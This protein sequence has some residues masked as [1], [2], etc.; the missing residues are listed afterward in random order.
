MVTTNDSRKYVL[1]AKIPGSDPFWLEGMV[2]SAAEGRGYAKIHRSNPARGVLLL[3]QLGSQLYQLRLP[4]MQQLEIICYTLRHAWMPLPKGVQV[5][6]GAEKADQLIRLVQS[7]WE[8]QGRPCRKETVDKA[9]EYARVRAAAFDP[10]NS[11]LLHGDAHAWNTLEVPGTHAKQFKF[12]DPDPVFGEF[13][14]DLAIPM[15]EWST[16]LLDGDPLVL[17]RERCTL[18]SRL[19]NVDPDAIWQWA[20]IQRV[21][22][23]LLALRNASLAEE[24]RKALKVADAWAT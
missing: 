7:E 5:V 21:S 16:E 9:I 11:V 2:L 10:Q 17:G 3:E 13:A 6:S 12:I 18:L 14:Y 22:N 4:L 23:G 24:G 15:R 1:K 19:S 20:L 8:A